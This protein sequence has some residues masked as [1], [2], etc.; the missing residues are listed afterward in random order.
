MSDLGT[1]WR[2]TY[3]MPINDPRFRSVRADQ[4]VAD[5]AIRAMYA[6]K[7]ERETNPT[8]ALARAAKEGDDAVKDMVSRG[9]DFL[10]RELAR[11]EDRQRATMDG[12]EHS[13]SPLT[14]SGRF[15][16]R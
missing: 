4:I 11:M 9:H 12:E 15:R 14:L 1:L 10:D 3:D 13:D 2:M 8:L 5:L 6:M 7:Y 16:A